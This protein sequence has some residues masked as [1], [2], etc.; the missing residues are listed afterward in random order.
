MMVSLIGNSS[1]LV[2]VGL[3]SLPEHLKTLG[4]QLEED[5]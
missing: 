4:V 3:S 1:I 2:F 5:E